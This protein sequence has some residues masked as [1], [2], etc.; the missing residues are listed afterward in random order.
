MLLAGTE[1]ECSGPVS[2]GGVTFQGLCG[3]KEGLL[4][5]CLVVLEPGE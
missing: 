3:G 5:A 2:V 1:T 4:A